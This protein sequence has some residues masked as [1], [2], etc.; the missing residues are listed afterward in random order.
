MKLIIFII[1]ILSFPL[2]AVTS[3]TSSKAETNENKT[4]FR[5][6]PLT[7]HI[8]NGSKWYLEGDE[9]THLKYIGEV[10]NDIPHGFGEEYLKGKKYFSGNYINGLRDGQGTYF[11]ED[12][13]TY[14]G[15]WKNNEANGLGIEKYTSEGVNAV[16][17]G[18]FKDNLRNGQ[19]SLTL[20]NGAS[21]K[22]EWVDNLLNG[23]VVEILSDGRKYEGNYKDGKRNG[24]GTFIW[25]DGQ[26][27]EGEWL[28]NE[29]HGYGIFNYS[30]G[31]YEGEFKT[32]KRNG[33]GTITYSNGTKYQGD[34]KNDLFNGF[35]IILEADGR[36]YEG[37]WKNDKKDGQGT[38][39]WP[40]GQ[41]YI[42][43]WQ[44]DERE[45]YSIEI[46][47]DGS[48]LWGER[49]EN[50]LQKGLKVNS[51]N[52]I[53][54]VA[55]NGVSVTTELEKDIIISD[56]INKLNE[57]TLFDQIFVHDPSLKKKIYLIAIESMNSNRKKLMTG[58]MP[59]GFI[60]N[61]PVNLLKLISNF[62]FEEASI[63]LEAIN[64]NKKPTMRIKKIDHNIN[65]IF[66]Y[67][68]EINDPEQT[69]LDIK[70]LGE[71]IEIEII[72]KPSWLLL[73]IDKSQANYIVK[74]TATEDIEAG[75]FSLDYIITDNVLGYKEY[76]HK[77]TINP[78][79]NTYKGYGFMLESSEADSP[80][81]C[82]D[83][84]TKG[85][86]IN[87][88]DIESD[89]YLNLNVKNE[90]YYYRGDLY[91]FRLGSLS[92]KKNKKYFIC[93]KIHI[94]Q[95]DF[96]EYTTRDVEIPSN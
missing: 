80:S 54:T 69:Q 46:Y 79:V 61:T 93:E 35:G 78:A 65:D 15:E 57:L 38:F 75:E 8:S 89:S 58:L 3:S 73:S 34:W 17:E 47:S 81:E 29:F 51:F 5:D 13:S 36:K 18:E 41:A 66:A 20:S 37:N 90:Y 27:Y 95:K 33:K 22:G 85:A 31:K 26:S 96:I 30:N 71:E 10:K 2:Q 49:K 28:N 63:L 56:T 21:F 77:I 62:E 43:E 42:G 12:G 67:N 40:D 39:I 76:K 16:Y 44:N 14:I 84:I 53:I 7:L 23:F 1:F 68:F 88:A 52:K 91:S 70:E 48:M 32:S 83:A 11:G 55:D 4:L 72:N 25:P 92:W 59:A 45:G 82:F 24:Q 87:L 19:G 9:L 74:L 94:N 50:I 6:T 64:A 60:T 86:L